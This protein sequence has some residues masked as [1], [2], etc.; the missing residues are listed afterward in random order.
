MESIIWYSGHHIL[1]KDVVKAEGCN[2]YTAD[3]KKYIDL[4]SGVWCTP[5]GHNNEAV[6]NALS[7]QMK[8]CFHTGYCYTSPVV[9]EAGKKIL[10][11]VSFA[12]GKLFFTTS[13]SEAVEF[14]VQI[15][16]KT[17]GKKLITF[18]DSFLGSHGS[19][20]SKSPEDWFLFNWQNCSGC[21]NECEL[22]PDFQSIAFEE[23]GGFVFEPGSAGG[24]VRFPPKKLVG[25]IAEKV[26]GDGGY[27]QVNEITTGMGRT[28]KMY[29]YMHYDLKPDIISLGKGLGNGY[30]VSVVIVSAAVADIITEQKYKFAQSHQNDP[31]GAAVALAVLNEFEREDVV[32][33]AADTGEYF[34]QR[35][36]KLKER[37]EY[38]EEVRGRGLMV[39]ITL[40]VLSENEI[41]DV[42]LKLVDSGYIL[43]KRPE[44]N[45]LRI[46]PPLTINREVLDGFLE[47]FEEILVKTAH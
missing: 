25:A 29:G 35:L 31:A 18:E 5:L 24:L 47:C 27:V 22:C 17:N 2:I 6:N 42:F 9:E 20:A 28:G 33:R 13:G 19:A 37:T 21:Q 34:I 23:I 43:V 39:S 11:T 26:K 41:N 8:K 40:R 10:D 7:D 14:G 44:L 12:D 30:P 16:L 1:L 15:L 32:S 4:E 46:D 45:V 3:G 38:I 36:Q